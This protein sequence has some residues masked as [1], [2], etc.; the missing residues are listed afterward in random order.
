MTTYVINAAT[1]GLTDFAGIS[2][3]AWAFHDD[4]TFLMT[5]DG[6]FELTGEDDDGTEIAWSMTTGN[7]RLNG[8]IAFNAFQVTPLVAADNPVSMSLLMKYRGTA[9]TIGPFTLTM[10]TDR[11]EVREWP[12]QTGEGHAPTAYALQLSGTGPARILGADIYITPH[13]R[14]R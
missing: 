2:A 7:M 11:D 9:S 6:L 12:T 14:G 5:D 8:G 13:V 10:P 4:R 3:H 1:F